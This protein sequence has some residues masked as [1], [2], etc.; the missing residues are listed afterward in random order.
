M[1]MYDCIGQVLVDDL[2]QPLPDRFFRPVV[3]FIEAVGL[4]LVKIGYTD[5]LIRR[6]KE[7][8]TSCPVAIRLIGFRSGGRRLEAKLHRD[9]ADYRS[10]GEWF[11]VSKLAMDQWRVEM[12]HPNSRSMYLDF[13]DTCEGNQ[14]D[15]RW[16]QR[17]KEIESF[18]DVY[19]EIM[20]EVAEGYA[21]V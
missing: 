16:R 12:D 5:E 18:D 14:E 10:V 4:D 15:I 3:Y 7:I 8:R 11:R 2:G 9:Y 21:N 17:P 13:R 20:E 19:A 1:V 6:F